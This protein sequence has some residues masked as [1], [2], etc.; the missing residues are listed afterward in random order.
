VNAQTAPSRLSLW[1]LASLPVAF[2]LCMP[3]AVTSIILASIG[4]V[5]ISRSK[6]RV[7]GKG[8][9]IIALTVSL[10]AIVL[11]IAALIWWDANVRAP[12]Q[13]GPREALILGIGG[14]TEGFRAAFAEPGRGRPEEAER[15]LT[16]VVSRYG[17]LRSIEADRF[18][19]TLTE[20]PAPSL[21]IVPYQLTFER[22][23]VRAQAM[24][25]TFA[26]SSG[27]PRP[28]LRWAWIHII[29]DELGDLIYPAAPLS[30]AGDAAAERMP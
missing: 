14:Q 20:P 1:A 10:I 19:E 18:A 23:V 13:Q 9:A 16:D 30:Y 26:P 7:R 11:Q 27:L 22:G 12:M 6:G 24:F 3:F 5:Q 21:P 25:V 28:V 17:L 2:F 8:V 15:F 29:D 4:W